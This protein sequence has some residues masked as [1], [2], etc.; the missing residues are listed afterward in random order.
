MVRREHGFGSEATF[1]P[2]RH[3]YTLLQEVMKAWYSNLVQGTP[4]T[5]AAREM[6]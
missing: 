3:P 5:Q 6:V 2:R 4:G 1:L